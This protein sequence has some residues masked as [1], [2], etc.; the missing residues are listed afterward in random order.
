MTQ[1]EKR[2]RNEVSM[3]CEGNLPSSTCIC[4]CVYDK[5]CILVRQYGVSPVLNLGQMRLCI[6]IWQ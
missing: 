6:S 3:S 1:G 2:P 5:V 4:G